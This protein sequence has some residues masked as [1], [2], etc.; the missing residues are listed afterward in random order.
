MGDKSVSSTFHANHTWRMKSRMYIEPLA[1]STSIT[2]SP[3]ICRL[4]T[5]LIPV[6]ETLAILLE[7]YTDDFL[8]GNAGLYS[9]T[10]S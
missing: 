1:L 10:H 5:F 7:V 4:L 6:S 9:K 3:I 2:V 8:L